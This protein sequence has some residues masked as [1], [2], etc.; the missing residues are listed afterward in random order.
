MNVNT[1]RKSSAPTSGGW[2]K[3]VTAPRG[4]QSPMA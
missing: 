2:S 3:Y 4:S 1:K